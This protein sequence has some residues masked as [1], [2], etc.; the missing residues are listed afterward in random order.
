MQENYLAKWLN[1]ELSEE[2]LVKFKAS[3]E[4]ASYEKLK[5]VSASLRAPDF[6]VED[7]LERVQTVRSQAS[8]KVI[9]MKPYKRFMRIAAAI[10][11]LITGSYLFLNLSN[12]SYS[13]ELAENTEVFLPDQ[14]EVIKTDFRASI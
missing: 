5:E 11:I 1:G 9:A 14:S 10:A 7:A 3:E 8:P 13:T 2:E 4:Y 6:D 12:T